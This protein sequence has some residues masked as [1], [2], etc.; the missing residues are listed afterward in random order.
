[1]LHYIFKV[2]IFQPAVVMKPHLRGW[3]KGIAVSSK[4]AWRRDLEASPGY[5][6]SSYFINKQTNN[7]NVPN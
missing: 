6:V 7:K 1:M 3:H 2:K 4:L 5:V